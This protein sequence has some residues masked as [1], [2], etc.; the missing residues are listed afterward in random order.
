ME[1]AKFTSEDQIK[2]GDDVVVYGKLM[3]YGTTNEIGSGNKL[4]SITRDA[5]GINGV[6]AEDADVNA[7]VYNLAGQRVNNTV[8]GIVIQNGKKFV[9]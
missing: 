3:L 6:V 8:K 2:V 5:D 1:G 7:P 4:Y 9:K